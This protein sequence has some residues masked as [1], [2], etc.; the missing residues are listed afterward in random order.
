MFVLARQQ[1]CLAWVEMA[2][3]HA[4]Q[5]CATAGQQLLSHTWGQT[6]G[7]VARPRDLAHPTKKKIPAQ[8]IN[9][10][11]FPYYSATSDFI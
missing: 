11:D 8:K 6:R 1:G 4:S 5:G 7:A 2:K 9:K 10:V 3:Q